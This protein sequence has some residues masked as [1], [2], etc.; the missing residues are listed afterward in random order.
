MVHLC[1]HKGV[2]DI[3][4]CLNGGDGTKSWIAYA[5]Q[6]MLLKKEKKGARGGG[7]GGGGAGL[8]QREHISLVLV[9]L[10]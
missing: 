4:A 5:G 1:Q 2:V 8:V 9:Y 10:V 7:G 6:S 3:V